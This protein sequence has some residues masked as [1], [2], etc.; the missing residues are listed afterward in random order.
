MALKRPRITHFV[1]HLNILL[2]SG[3]H[4]YCIGDVLQGAAGGR[5]VLP[6]VLQVYQVPHVQGHNPVVVEVLVHHH[7]HRGFLVVQHVW[8]EIK[9]D[10]EHGSLLGQPVGW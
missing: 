9:D 4:E 8:T 1:H 2:V 10:H 3:L 7:A 5:V 6:V